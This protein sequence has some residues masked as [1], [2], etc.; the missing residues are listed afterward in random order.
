VVNF[1]DPAARQKGDA[2]ENLVEDFIRDLQKLLRRYK[3]PCLY[4]KS[5]SY[6]GKGR[7]NIDFL[8]LFRGRNKIRYYFYVDPKNFNR[9][10]KNAENIEEKINKKFEREKDFWEPEESS[11]KLG[12][13]L[14]SFRMKPDEIEKLKRK[15][16]YYLDLG[17]LGTYRKIDGKGKFF[18]NE[19]DKIWYDFILRGRLMQFLA[20]HTKGVFEVFPSKY[21]IEIKSEKHF[22]II[23]ERKSMNYNIEPLFDVEYLPVNNENMMDFIT[24]EKGLKGGVK[25]TS[26]WKGFTKN[27]KISVRNTRFG[28]S[29][30]KT[31]W[32]RKRKKLDP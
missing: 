6:P 26:P 8:L 15:N 16:I 28:T 10:M 21:K 19:G 7:T 32:G 24:L 2:L 5:D 31:Q 3:R 4:V 30:Y 27:S 17:E 14:G 29:L 11:K 22:S 25:I 13:I 23:K 9:K 20:F 1:E 12:V 18:L